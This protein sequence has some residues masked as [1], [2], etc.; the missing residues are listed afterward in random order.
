[1][2]TDALQVAQALYKNC[3]QFGFADFLFESL[4]M[5]ALDKYRQTAE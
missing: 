4:K 3:I 1:M 2:I 5:N